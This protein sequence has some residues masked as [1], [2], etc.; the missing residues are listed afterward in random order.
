[1]SH[2]KAWFD[3]ADKGKTRGNWLVLKG[4]HMSIP[5][6]ADLKN[7][8]LPQHTFLPPSFYVYTLYI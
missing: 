1:M 3:S 4:F 7:Q 5:N 6:P 8:L 2:L